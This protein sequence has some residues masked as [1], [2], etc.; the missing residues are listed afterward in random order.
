MKKLVKESLSHE[1]RPE[2][3]YVVCRSG[4]MLQ[5]SIHS[6]EEIYTDMGDARPQAMFLNSQGYKSGEIT[7]A[8]EYRVYT[9]QDIID[10]VD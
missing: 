7:R 2:E 8:T 6:I 10:M 5:G 4:D 3:L 9:I 1:F